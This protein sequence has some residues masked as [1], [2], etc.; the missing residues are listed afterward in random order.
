ML[1]G[2]RARPGAKEKDMD[3]DA[4]SQALRR[5]LVVAGRLTGRG[6]MQVIGGTREV[7]RA[8]AIVAI[9]IGGATMGIL[10][11]AWLLKNDAPWLRLEGWLQWRDPSGKL[12]QPLRERL[13]YGV[14]AFGGSR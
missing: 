10:A 4:I 13:T 3:L 12:G 11:V 9:P 8:V 2:D 6:G 7:V 14:A 5:R 1:K